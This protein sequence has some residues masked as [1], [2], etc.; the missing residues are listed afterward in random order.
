M[1]E[2]TVKATRWLG[3]L[4]P[5]VGFLVGAAA[6]TA[7][8]VANGQSTIRQPGEHPDYAVELE[9]HLLAGLFDPPGL[10]D[11]SGIGAG[12]RL[13]I[14]IVRNGFIPNINNSVGISFGIDWVHYEGDEFVMGS[15]ARR[16][17]GPGGVSVCTEVLAPVGGKSNYLYFPAAMQW[18]FWLAE[19]FSVFGEPGLALYYEKSRAEVESHVGI[20][21]VFLVGGRWHF[22]RRAMLT[23]RIGYP[24]MSLG[25]SVLL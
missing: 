9:P 11:G 1:I 12:L 17:T 5:F 7:T 2:M 18:N 25:V 4:R 24:A 3:A 15:C 20:A 14:P 19:K 22:L 6:V 10:P 21:P 8:G 16:V 13:T 23:A